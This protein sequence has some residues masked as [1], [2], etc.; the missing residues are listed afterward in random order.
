MDIRYSLNKSSFPPYSDKKGCGGKDKRWKVVT[1]T[2]VS[3]MSTMGCFS[4]N[5]WGSAKSC[6]IVTLFSEGG[7]CQ[8]FLW[9]IA[10]KWEPPPSSSRM[11]KYFQLS[12]G[13]KEEGSCL[14][15]GIE[16]PCLLRTSELFLRQS[17][18]S[19]V[20]TACS[21]SQEATKQS[22]LF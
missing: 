8:S 15:V 11:S 1:I 21:V 4:G 10:V 5:R 16:A 20:F 19:V 12:L 13:Q 14:D 6:L 9:A 17:V 7:G 18:V 3:G 22:I 2:F